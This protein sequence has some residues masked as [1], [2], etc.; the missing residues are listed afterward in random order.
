MK[1]KVDFV[2]IAIELF[3]LLRNWLLVFTTGLFFTFVGISVSLGYPDEFDS[4][5]VSLVIIYSLFIV[6]FW[7]ILDWRLVPLKTKDGHLTVRGLLFFLD[8]KCILSQPTNLTSVCI[9]P[10]GIPKKQFSKRLVTF[11]SEDK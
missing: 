11:T 5:V 10:K 2:F 3:T 4:G 1:R 7:R 8:R 6:I 9:E